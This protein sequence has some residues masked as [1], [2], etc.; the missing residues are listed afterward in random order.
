VCLR[1]EARGSPCLDPWMGAAAGGCWVERL[2]HRAEG[3]GVADVG[4]ES[5]AVGGA[6]LRK[7]G[8]R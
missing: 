2:G 7:G 6:G 1:S 4:W 3:V 8:S 5:A